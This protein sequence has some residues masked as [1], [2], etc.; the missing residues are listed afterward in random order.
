MKQTAEQKKRERLLDQE[1]I[2][3]LV[4]VHHNIHSC[5]EIDQMIE[6]SQGEMNWQA[7]PVCGAE[8]KEDGSINH[9]MQ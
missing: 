1:W 2:E 3:D 4:F 7:C 5:A 9:R 8:I 6:L